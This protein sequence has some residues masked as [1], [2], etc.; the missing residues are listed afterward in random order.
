MPNTVKAKLLLGWMTEF[1]AMHF[2]RNCVFDPPKTDDEMLALWRLYRDK[3][4]AIGKRQVPKF[5]TH[6]LSLAEESTGK[7]IVNKARRTNG[8]NVKRVIKIDPRDLLIHQLYVI[9]DQSGKYAVHMLDKRK[10]L[11]VCLGIGMENKTPIGPAVRDGNW[12]K[13]IVPHGEFV[14]FAIN[15]KIVMNGPND[16]HAQEQ[17]RF[18][19]FTQFDEKLLLWAGYHRSHALVSQTKPEDTERLLVGTLVT[20]GEAFLGASSVLPDKRAVVRGDCPP[21]FSD[22]FNPE[23]CIIVDYLEMR[24]ELHCNPVTGEYRV[25][26]VPI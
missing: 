1:E 16:F 22:F 8:T 10:R 17:A 4:S 26:M 6:K 18:I 11:N 19:S 2:L 5:K 9:T 7:T 14:P 13:K 21:L 12:L 20:D 23:L 15:G 24:C 3:V 25:P